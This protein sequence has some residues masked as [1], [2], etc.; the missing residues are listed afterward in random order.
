VFTL[1]FISFPPCYFLFIF[2]AI[3]PETAAGTRLAG[4]KSIE[5]SFKENDE[6]TVNN[7]NDKIRMIKPIIKPEIRPFFLSLNTNTKEEIKLDA[8]TQTKA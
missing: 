3:I 6:N 1:Y 8:A 7:M 4:I 2:T 5:F